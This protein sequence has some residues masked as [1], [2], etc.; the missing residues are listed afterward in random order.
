MDGDR[1]ASSAKRPITREGE[2]PLQ[3]LAGAL[4]PEPGD[5]DGDRPLA[6]FYGEEGTLVGFASAG[7]QRIDHEGVRHA[8]YGG[9]LFIDTQYKGVTES[10]SFAIREAL[11]FRLRE[12]WTPLWCMGVIMTPASYRRLVVTMPRLYPGRR[13]PVPERV[14]AL[15]RKTA[16]LRGLAFVDE[17][18]WLV[19]GMGT[20]RHPERLR[21]ARTLK[22]DPDARFFLDEN[23]RFDEGVAMLIW[24]PVDVRNLGGAFARY[25]AR[26]LTGGD[27]SEG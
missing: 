23:P 9:M 8:V 27:R 10:L 7:I 2:Q 3:Q 5:P 6:L 20:P 15:L 19:R 17:E 11:R 12:P 24:F 13:A 14:R 18:R 25:F 26:L 4:D 21:S 22:A 1:L 16:R